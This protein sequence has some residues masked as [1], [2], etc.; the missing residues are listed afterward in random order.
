MDAA[1]VDF[2]PTKRTKSNVVGVG[3]TSGRSWK[4]PGQRAGSLRNPKLSTSWEKKM[5]DKA[6]AQAFRDAKKEAKALVGEAKREARERKEAA[7]ARK[8]ENRRNSE[9]TVRVSAETAKKM[10]KS[11][12]DR[13]KLRAG[14]V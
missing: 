3:R 7:K 8:E 6:K 5:A 12:K 1:A 4:A 13:K 14:G 2:A 11:K 10:L 9:V